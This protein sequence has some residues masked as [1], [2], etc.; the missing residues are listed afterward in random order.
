M[1]IIYDKGGK[2]KDSIF[3][4]NFYNNAQELRHV[5]GKNVVYYNFTPACIV[6]KE[7]PVVQHDYGNRDIDEFGRSIMQTIG[8]KV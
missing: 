7:S 3:T 6:D 2:F 5:Y 1:A 4:D 8:E